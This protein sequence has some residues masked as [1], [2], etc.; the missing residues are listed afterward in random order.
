M[1][2]NVKLTSPGTVPVRF[3]TNATPIVIRNDALLATSELRNLVDVVMQDQSD[4]NTLVYNAEEEKFIL[5]SP[6]NL[7]ITSI[8][9]GSF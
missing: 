3:T 9:G 8:D 5:E 6:D 2:I 7:N 4:G 1:P